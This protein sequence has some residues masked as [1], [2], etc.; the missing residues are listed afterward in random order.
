MNFQYTP[1]LDHVQVLADEPAANDP[2]LL[3]T[4]HRVRAH[5]ASEPE[6]RGGQ[7]RA[8]RPLAPPAAVDVGPPGCP[9]SV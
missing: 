6:P 2:D 8:P 7:I 1:Y 3:R 9:L 4:G 5:P